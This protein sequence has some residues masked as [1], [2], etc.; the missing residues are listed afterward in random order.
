MRWCH[1]GDV[2]FSGVVMS[3]STWML[4][5]CP[6]TSRGSP[7]PVFSLAQALLEVGLL[8]SVHP[9]GKVHP[10]GRQLRLEL[11]HTQRVCST[12]RSRRRT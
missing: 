1:T 10:K 3:W 4:C 6:R 5:M 11:A 9:C 12:E 2:S 7:R 8:D